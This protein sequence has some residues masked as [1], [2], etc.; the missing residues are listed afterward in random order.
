MPF[1]DT[2]PV[3]KGVEGVPS[4]DHPRRDSRH[5]PTC[6]AMAILP[7]D[8]PREANGAIQDPVMLC[9]MCEVEFTATGMRFVAARPPELGTL[10][11][12]EVRTWARAFVDAVLGPA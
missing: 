11:E 6:G 8:Q 12:D 9:P 7:V 10:S 2:A 3:R 4:T 1:E 5:C